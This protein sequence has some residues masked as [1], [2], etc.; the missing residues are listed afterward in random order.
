M[1]LP[2]PT[3]LLIQA[4]YHEGQESLPPPISGLSGQEGPQRAL[5]PLPHFIIPGA[6]CDPEI[7]H[8]TQGHPAIQK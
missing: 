7:G 3:S 2:L 8:I 6:R 4:L 1:S 5:A